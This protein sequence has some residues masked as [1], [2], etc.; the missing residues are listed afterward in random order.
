MSSRTPGSPDRAVIL[1]GTVLILVLVAGFLVLSVRGLDTTAYALFCGGPVTT[2]IIGAVVTKRVSGVAAAVQD[3][4]RKTVTLGA[5]V[6]IPAAELVAPEPTQKPAWRLSG[7][8]PD[9]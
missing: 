7:F 5:A 8:G 9:P 4:D 3:V 6:G 2:T 1:A